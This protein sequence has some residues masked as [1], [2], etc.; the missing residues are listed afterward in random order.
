M[1]LDDSLLMART[2]FF[3]ENYL[4]LGH[5]LGGALRSG[6]TFDDDD[7]FLE[8]YY[9]EYQ[10]PGLGLFFCQ[11]KDDDEAGMYS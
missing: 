11:D 3:T 2:T 7:S 4:S 10:G 5:A 8:F 9:W 6:A 1:G